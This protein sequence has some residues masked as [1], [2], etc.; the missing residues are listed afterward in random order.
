MNRVISVTYP[1]PCV[2]RRAVLAYAGGGKDPRTAS[3]ADECISEAMETFT[4]SVCYVKSELSLCGSSVG[5]GNTTAHSSSLAKRLD[6]CKSAIIFA[7]TVGFG[8][9]RLIMRYS[10]VRPAKAL[11]LQAIGAERIEAL[12][13]AFCADAEK[14]YG[15]LRA[16]F[17]PGY[18]DLPLDFQRDIFALLDCKRSVGIS[19]N[20]SLLMS[21][22]KSVTAIVGIEN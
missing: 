7:A 19:L 5:F 21:P 13:D 11:M 20:E 10:A 12:C 15:S 6:G 22:T 1:A 8:I 14:R 17:S 16:R 18:G 3:L 9:D 4:Y 2:D